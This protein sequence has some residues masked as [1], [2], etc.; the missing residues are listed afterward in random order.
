MGVLLLLLWREGGVRLR[1]RARLRLLILLLV[2]KRWLVLLRRRLGMLV[3]LLLLEG[4]VRRLLLIV[5]SVLLLERWL[6]LPLI[7]LGRPRLLL[8]ASVHRWCLHRIRRGAV[9]AVA[10]AVVVVAAAVAAVCRLLVIRGWS[11]CACLVS[12]PPV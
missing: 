3:L 6:L 4:L 7:T 12:L 2:R 1:L 9:V 10:V 11:R 8:T 5:W